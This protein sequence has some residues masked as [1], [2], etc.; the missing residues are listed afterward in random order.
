M[1]NLLRN[2]VPCLKVSHKRSA[3]D[4]LRVRIKEFN[5]SL[6][7]KLVDEGKGEIV[8]DDPFKEKRTKGLVVSLVSFRF[9]KEGLSW[10][11]FTSQSCLYLLLLLRR[12]RD[13]W[14]VLLVVGFVI[15]SSR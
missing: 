13:P 8:F 11:S 5:K 12:E 14:V 4:L 9:L 7:F 3:R 2:L 10:L 6:R 15:I 1:F